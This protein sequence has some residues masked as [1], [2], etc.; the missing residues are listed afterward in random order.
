MSLAP[1]DTPLTAL[2]AAFDA[3]WS[4]RD[5]QRHLG[6]VPLERIRAVPSPGAATESDA[7]RVLESGAGP[8]C[9]LI[10]GVLVEKSMGYKEARLAVLL[11]TMLQNFVGPRNLGVVVGAD[12]TI[13]LPENLIRIPDVSFAAWNRFPGGRIPDEAAPTIV[14]DLCVEIISAGNTRAEMQRKLREYFSGGVRLVW[15]VDWRAK[16]VDVYQSPTESRTLSAR[17]TLEGGDVL[18]GFQL[19]I[20]DLFVEL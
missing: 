14:P 19:A 4:L 2:P 20:A 10:D 17:E 8:R 15:L 18:P 13:R 3:A 7:V 11:A 1:H 16:T 12:G 5:L 9:E 6:D